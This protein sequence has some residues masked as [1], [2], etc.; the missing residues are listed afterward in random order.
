MTEF[1]LPRP[2]HKRSVKH[3]RLTASDIVLLQEIANDVPLRMVA[4]R[5]RR[6]YKALWYQIYAIRRAMNARHTP[7]AVA[8]ALR[9]GI[10]R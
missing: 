7:A 8:I 2:Y 1:R 3:P 9:S 6:S 5:Q 4:K 10:I